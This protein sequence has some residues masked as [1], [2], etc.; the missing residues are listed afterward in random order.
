M[1]YY[2]KKSVSKFLEYS[3][4]MALGI[5]ADDFVKGKIL[6]YNFDNAKVDETVTFYYEAEEAESTKSKEYGEQLE[7]KINFDRIMEEAQA[8]ARKHI[9]LLKLALRDNEEKQRK[10]FLVGQPRF[11]RLADWFKYM[12]EMYDRILAD[13]NVVNSVT[14]YSITRQNL[15]EGRQKII[16]AAAAKA[17]HTKEQGEAEAATEHRDAIFFKLSERIHELEVICPY[18]LEDTPQYLETLGITVLSPGYK[19]KTKSEDDTEDEEKETDE[20]ETTDGNGGT[21]GTGGTSNSVQTTSPE[22]K[23]KKSKHK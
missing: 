9:D 17:R 3:R 23:K 7:A 21:G 11:R 15:E 6:P 18:A 20:T 16:D 5:Q 4:V 10:L 19:R 2:T 1:L 12:H 22:K 13:D 14:I 8:L